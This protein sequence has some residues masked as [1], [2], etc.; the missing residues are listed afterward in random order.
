MTR[1]MKKVNKY[2]NDIGVLGGGGCLGPP[3]NG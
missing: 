1:H 3:K 2:I